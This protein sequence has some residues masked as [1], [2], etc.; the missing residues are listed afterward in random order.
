MVAKPSLRAILAESYVAAVAVAVLLVLS[1]E[2]SFIFLW[3]LL[4]LLL[5]VAEFLATAVAI[6]GLP[7]GYGRQA[8]W[9]WLLVS[10]A[11]LFDALVKFGAAWILSRYV[12]G[13]NPFS[14]LG[15]CCF[16]LV[17]RAHV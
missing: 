6:F 4:K 13:L 16:D 5:I 8:D 17:R 2:A 11:F 12:Y 15:K 10:F 7:S 14:A 3:Y 1:F 9:P